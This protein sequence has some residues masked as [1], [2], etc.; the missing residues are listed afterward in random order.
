MLTSSF[1]LA[2]AGL[3]TFSTA[4]PT[5]K[6]SGAKR[7]AGGKRGCAFRKGEAENAFQDKTALFTGA[8]QVSWGY[9]WEARSWQDF[10]GNVGYTAPGVE[11]VPMLHDDGPVFKP[12]F[13]SDTR[14]AIAAGSTHIL[15]VNEPNICG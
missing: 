12:G 6:K 11:F 13:V 10:S 9:S 1:V 14:A 8:G 5:A 4:A 2:L 15:S 7:Q 3:A